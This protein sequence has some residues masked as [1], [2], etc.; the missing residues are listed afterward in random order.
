MAYE[1]QHAWAEPWDRQPE[2]TSLAWEY[3][4]YYRSLGYGRT[5]KAVADHF[6]L[7][8]QSMYNHARNHSWTERVSAW[9]VYEDRIY[10]AELAQ[11][12][13][14]M[15]QRHAKQAQ[16]ALMALSKPVEAI[17][18]KLEDPDAILE[19]KDMDIMQLMKMVVP[20][21]RAMTQVADTERLALG[22]PTEIT[23]VQGE[24]QHTH[25]NEQTDEELLDTL[26]EVRHILTAL[27]AGEGE[28]GEIID[29]EIIEI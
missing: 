1:I 10:Q 17:L 28:A 7:H 8:P 23:N 15:A 13:K 27:P 20:A 21:V 3:F 2:E 29:A 18:S 6:K 9:D 14:R 16:D 26:R 11:E 25:K 12:R 24:V 4:Q 22:A 19:M 5:I